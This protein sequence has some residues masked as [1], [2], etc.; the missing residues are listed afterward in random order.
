MSN[1]KKITKEW[2]V[3]NYDKQISQSFAKMKT[4]FSKRNY[5]TMQEYD[6]SMI[7]IPLSK[8]LRNK[9]LQAL[10]QITKKVNK[11]WK[12]VLRDDID[13]IT[14]WIMETYGDHKGQET[15]SS[16]DMKKVLKL[17][18][19]WFKTGE[20][21]KRPN[22]P[23]PY[24]IQG[25]TLGKVKDRIVR[26]DL[27]TE[28]DLEKLL[29]ACL[30]VRDKAFIHTHYEAGT[31][32]GEIL[33]LRIKDVKFDEH[34]AL[35]NVIGKTYARP[36]RLIHSVPNLLTWI[37]NHPYK[38]DPDSALWIITEK[39]HYGQPMSYATADRLLK[40]AL[41]RSK[42]NKKIN[43]NLFRHSEAT[44]TANFMT[45]PQLRKRHGWT[46]NSK[47]TARYVHLVNADVENAIFEHYGIKKKEEKKQ[48]MPTKCQFC[49]MFNPV[50]SEVCSKCAK[51]LDIEAA[52]KLDEKTQEEKEKLAKKIET[53]ES[54]MIELANQKQDESEK[55][56]LSN[57][58][59]RKL[60]KSELKTILTDPKK[61]EKLL[62]QLDSDD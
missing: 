21:R 49:D 38:D 30:S 15:H 16:Y 27:V 20:R 3:H 11:D 48:D 28:D 54:K 9:H 39:H 17:F 55:K 6:K 60:I 10:L 45:E 51:P 22:Q 8:A 26:E 24:E 25:V 13:D 31:R 33:S 18:Y 44:R 53:L 35:I 5:E 7:R 40:N 36:I 59:V 58:L 1:Q 32:P 46:A 23:E 2:D 61:K 56:A 47:M 14:V 43:L 37:Q 19:R 29:V 12:D 62:D 42:L 57:N 50:G 41:K 34:G 4:A 52:I